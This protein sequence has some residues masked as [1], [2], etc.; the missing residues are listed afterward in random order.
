MHFS[1]NW[2]KRVEKKI[3][4]LRVSKTRLRLQVCEALSFSL[5]LGY[6]LT[7]ADEEGN[8]TSEMDLTEQVLFFQSGTTNSRQKYR[9]VFRLFFNFFNNAKFKITKGLIKR[10]EPWVPCKEY[11]V[12]GMPSDLIELR[13]EHLQRSSEEHNSMQARSSA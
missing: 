7:S 11:L 13:R 3:W 8:S 10:L 12:L 4:A 1:W 5:S 9:H 2:V 6:N